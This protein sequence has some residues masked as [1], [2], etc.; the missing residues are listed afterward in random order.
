MRDSVAHYPDFISC[1]DTYNR[2]D[3]VVTIV[4]ASGYAVHNWVTHNGDDQKG[5]RE[6]SSET[7]STSA[8]S[9]PNEAASSGSV[10]VDPEAKNLIEC[11]GDR[12]R[13]K[14]EGGYRT[15]LR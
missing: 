8:E 6:R 11:R 9:N 5:R 2:N 7:G 15:F 3:S 13:R 1:T 14:S 12:P 4:S 10:G